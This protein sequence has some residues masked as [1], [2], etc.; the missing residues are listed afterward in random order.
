LLLCA[1]MQRS[2]LTAH[3]QPGRDSSSRSYSC[4]QARSTSLAHCL[5][6]RLSVA[7]KQ[8]LH[9]DGT[10]VCSVTLQPRHF[11][12]KS[13]FLLDQPCLFSCHWNPG[14]LLAGWKDLATYTQ[15]LQ[16][17]VSSASARP[18]H[19][20]WHELSA[21]WSL[22]TFITRWAIFPVIAHSCV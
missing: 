11:S 15:T 5:F 7:C 4:L 14:S 17:G 10:I 8:K 1:L 3:D 6:I 18:Q 21:G 20:A 12:S 13:N 19:G 22:Q 16:T 9:T 2:L